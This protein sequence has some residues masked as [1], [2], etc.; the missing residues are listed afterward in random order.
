MSES[1]DALDEKWRVLHASKV[2]TSRKVT[3]LKYCPDGSPCALKCAYLPQDYAKPAGRKPTEVILPLYERDEMRFLAVYDLCRACGKD[4][5][6]SHKEARAGKEGTVMDTHIFYGP[7][8]K[9]RQFVT[10][11][12]AIIQVQHALEIKSAK[13]KELKNK[14][15]HLFGVLDGRKSPLM[16]PG[17]AKH[18]GDGENQKK[19]KAGVSTAAS[20]QATKSKPVDAKSDTEAGELNPEMQRQ[21]ERNKRN[22]TQRESANTPEKNTRLEEFLSEP[23]KSKRKASN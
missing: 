13:R 15:L 3:E 22:K 4:E 18:A 20:T 6:D 21:M 17:P 23:T 7:D 10:F 5:Y 16:P 11:A 9:L 12:Y 19:R 14:F 8:G 1:Q 2:P